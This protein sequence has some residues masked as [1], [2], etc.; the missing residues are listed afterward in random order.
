MF[1]NRP[2]MIFMKKWMPTALLLM[3]TGF[4]SCQQEK[5]EDKAE[6]LKKELTEAVEATKEYI[7]AQTK[8]LQ[9][10]YRQELLE[11]DEKYREVKNKAMDASLDV[12]MEFKDVM[13]EILEE[14]NEMQQKIAELDQEEA[15]ERLR[16]Q[17]D[18]LNELIN[19][20]LDEWKKKLQ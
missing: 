6:K 19:R 10:D 14:K 11:I 20:T 15:K 9:A 2:V 12:Q 16:T 5:P 18:S 1:T 3:A 7:E 13:R 8:D 4:I 17:I